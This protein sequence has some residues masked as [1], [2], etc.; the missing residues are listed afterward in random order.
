MRK[1]WRTTPRRAQITAKT[2]RDAR[3]V[4]P[5]T[6]YECNKRERDDDTMMGA[7][8]EKVMRVGPASETMQPTDEEQ[9]A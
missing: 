1:K 5:L 8:Q 2:T 7:K 3:T 9:T 4:P 6:K